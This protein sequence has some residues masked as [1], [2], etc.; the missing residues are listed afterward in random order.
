MIGAIG[1]GHDREN[2][3]RGNLDDIDPH[4]DRRAAI[5]AAVGDVTHEQREYDAEQPHEQRAVVSAAE[6]VRPKLAG[7]IAAENRRNPDHQAGINP[8]IQ[9][10]GPAGEK[11]GDA[12]KFIRMGL[13]QERL[14]GVKVGRT[15]AGI[16]FGELGI[17]DAPSRSTTATRPAGRP[18][19]RSRP[20]ARRRDIALGTSATRMRRAQ[21]RP[22]R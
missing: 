17:A 6:S 8:V 15:R 12:R 1:D 9:M 13:G 16:E 21:S 3:Q 10:A 11:F 20:S 2:H 18:T 5:H 19:S 14:L 22:W 7:Q 4:V